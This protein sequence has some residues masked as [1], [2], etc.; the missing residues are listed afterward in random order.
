MFKSI[1]TKYIMSFVTLLAVGFIAIAVVITSVITTYSIRSKETLMYRT[2]RV[3]YTNIDSIMKSS[4]LSFSNAV[5]SGG[6][7]LNEVI[8]QLSL[9]SESAVIITDS[10]G[11]ILLLAGGEVSG[12]DKDYTGKTSIDNM[13]GASTDYDYSDLSGL[14]KH[15]RF[16][17]IYPVNNTSESSDSPS[18]A[19]RIILSSPATGLQGMYDQ[20]IKIIIFASLWIFVAAVVAVYFITDRIITPLKSMNAAAKNYSKGDFSSRV[21]VSGTDEI[22][23]LAATFNQM[24]DSLSVLDSTRSNF[25]SSVSHDL[26]TPMTSIQGFIDGIL[27]GTIPPEK[28][29]YYLN[30]V[31]VEVKR[32]SRL[33]SS[34]LDI[35]RMESGSFKLQ[36]SK[37]DI[38][39]IARIILISFEEKIDEKKINIEFETESD[40]SEVFADKDAVHQILYNLVD[41]ALKFTNENGV[42][43]IAIKNSGAKHSISVFNTGL[44]IVKEELPFVFDRFY[45]AD[46]SRGLDKTGTGLGLYIAKSKIES[47]GEKITVNSEYGKN[48]E[49][50]FTLPKA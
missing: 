24:A 15:R 25:L 28:Q 22:A 18:V 43:K 13:H 1:Y 40:P 6:K 14:L 33:V 45:K 10:T 42:L 34:L 5:S 26:R 37:F 47:H 8:D 48:C 7:L 21:Q 50:V 35:S 30:I 27:D 36:K 2:A 32:L 11:N 16:N 38:C 46:S 44:G 19:G 23:E 4:D 41:N 17:Y 12:F 29:S 49:F 3:V 39:E 20:I 31:S 9:Y